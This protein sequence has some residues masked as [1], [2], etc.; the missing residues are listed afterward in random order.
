MTYVVQ[1][2]ECLASERA[3][4]QPPAYFGCTS[5][6]NAELFSKRFESVRLF[7]RCTART[8][9]LAGASFATVRLTRVPAGINPD[10]ESRAWERNPR[11]MPARLRERSLPVRAVEIGGWVRRAPRVP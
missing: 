11:P 3:P 2:L 6:H 4:Q 7:L 5:F 8:E 10:G 1:A 9:L